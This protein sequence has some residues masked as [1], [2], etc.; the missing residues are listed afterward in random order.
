MRIA[1]VS[2]GIALLIAL[3]AWALLIILDPRMSLD[4]AYGLIVGSFLGSTILTALVLTLRDR[5]RKQEH[6]PSS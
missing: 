6:S 1:F 3:L 2:F 5:S 4:M